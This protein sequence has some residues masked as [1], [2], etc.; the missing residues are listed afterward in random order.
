MKTFGL[1]NLGIF[2]LLLEAMTPAY[3][4]HDQREQESRRPNQEQ[5]AKPERQQAPPNPGK[6][7]QQVK[8]AGQEAPRRSK[9][10]APNRRP[11]PASSARPEEPQ[12]AR[13]QQER[14]QQNV[15]AQQEQK[16]RPPQVKGQQDQKQKQEQPRQQ[17]AKQPVQ[18]VQR[19]YENQHRGA[20]LDRR[21]NNWQAEHR[22]W[23]QRGGYTGYRIPDARYRGF[24]GPSHSFRM[25]SFPLLVVG[26]FP[27]FQYGGLWFSVIDPWP[28]YWSN[29]WYDSD[30][31][32]VEFYG[33]GY[34]LRN[35]MHPRDRMAL[36]VFI[37]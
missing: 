7:P 31:L 4:Q 35:R 21:A 8:P 16:Q 10:P 32:Y 3:A 36:T 33:G 22:S 27:R 29:N 24:F 5:Q 14:Q 37:N 6:Q 18:Q 20:W 9:E 12:R 1:I 28:E 34:Y 17:Q 15:K 11:Q 19:E 30:D 2:P 23:Q 13:G 25:F 26:G